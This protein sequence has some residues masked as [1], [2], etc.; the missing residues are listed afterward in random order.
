MATSKDTTDWKRVHQLENAKG[1]PPTPIGPMKESPTR[2][3]LARGA[4]QSVGN[5]GQV[6]DRGELMKLLERQM[7]ARARRRNMGGMP[8]EMAVRDLKGL[9]GGG[10]NRGKRD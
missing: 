8:I 2:E 10:Q 9:F 5:G 6:A 7:R 4:R 1:A 3:L